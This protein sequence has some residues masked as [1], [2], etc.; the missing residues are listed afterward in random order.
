MAEQQGGNGMKD[1]E[2]EAFG[3]FLTIILVGMFVTILLMASGKPMEAIATA[4]I[5]HGIMTIL[6]NGK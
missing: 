1:V 6:A 3:F 4:I 5:T 2:K